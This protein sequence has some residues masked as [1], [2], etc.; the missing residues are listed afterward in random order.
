MASWYYYE[1]YSPTDC[2]WNWN[3]R[4]RIQVIDSEDEDMRLWLDVKPEQTI[5]EVLREIARRWHCHAEFKICHNHELS[6]EDVLDDAEQL[7]AELLGGWIRVNCK[8]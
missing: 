8:K 4:P 7:P 2:V 6:I 1:M 5:R 3:Y